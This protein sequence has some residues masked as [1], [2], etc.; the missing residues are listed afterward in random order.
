MLQQSEKENMEGWRARKDCKYL[1]P[2]QYLSL[3][4]YLRHLNLLPRYALCVKD[5]SNQIVIFSR[6]FKPFRSRPHSLR[7][8]LWQGLLLMKERSVWVIHDLIE[9]SA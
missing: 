6:R 2:L 1:A 7:F 8:I 5:W 4:D 3:R 9:E